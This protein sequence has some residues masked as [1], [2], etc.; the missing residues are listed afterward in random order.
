[1][2]LVGATPTGPSV[3]SNGRTETMGLKYGA[4]IVY[5]LI[6]YLSFSGA[7]AQTI[8]EKWR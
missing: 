3:D 2:R 1:M 4:G 8:V 5:F 6:D 7:I